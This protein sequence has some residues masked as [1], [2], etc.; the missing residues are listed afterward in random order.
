MKYKSC[1][2]ASPKMLSALRMK[3]KVSETT[4]KI[5]AANQQWKCAR[6]GELLTAFYEIDHII[7]LWRG[8]TNDPSNLQAL[9]RECHAAKGAYERLAPAA[10]PVNTSVERFNALFEPF[11]G[12]A[13]PLVVAKQISQNKFGHAFDEKV[14]QVAVEPHMVFPPYWRQLFIDQRME[15]QEAGPVLQGVRLRKPKTSTRSV[16]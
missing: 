4:K 8:G 6:C 14:I 3:R 15:P 13:F 16:A 7:G 5:V 9:H 10:E 12:G 11:Y 2:P 1:E